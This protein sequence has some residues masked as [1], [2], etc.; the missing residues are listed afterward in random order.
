MKKHVFKRITAMV[1]IFV[2]CVFLMPTNSLG[3]K[4][5]STDDVLVDETQ[6]TSEITT[7]DVTSTELTSEI[8]EEEISEN[9]EEGTSEDI[10]NESAS[11][12][13]DATAEEL[14]E[15]SDEY[16]VEDSNMV[17]AGNTVGQWTLSYDDVSETYNSFGE[18]SARIDELDNAE[19][20]Y[21][22]MGD[23]ESGGLV[24]FDEAFPTKATELIFK[25]TS[26]RRYVYTGRLEADYKV[27][28]GVNF[29]MLSGGNIK[30]LYASEGLS[31]YSSVAG[32]TVNIETL[33][34]YPYVHATTRVK[35]DT[36]NLGGAS[37]GFFLDSSFIDWS[38]G[39]TVYSTEGTYDIT[40]IN[41][42]QGPN[43]KWEYFRFDFDE[44]YESGHV[45]FT[46]STVI[47]EDNIYQDMIGSNIGVVVENENETCSI[48][49]MEN[50]TY[51]YLLS[52][53]NKVEGYRHYYELVDRIDELNNKSRVYTIKITDENSGSEGIS[54]WPEAAKKLIIVAP[55]RNK[56]SPSGDVC[57]DLFLGGSV[58]EYPIETKGWENIEFNR[59]AKIE[60]IKCLDADMTLT[61]SE[62]CIIN[63]LTINSSTALNILGSVTIGT[64]TYQYKSSYSNPVMEFSYD[65]YQSGS[66]YT[67]SY[68]ALNVNKITVASGI[69]RIELSINHNKEIIDIPILEITNCTSAVWSLINVSAYD[70]KI[71]YTVNESTT[72][73]GSRILQWEEDEITT[74]KLQYGDVEEIF[75]TL[76]QVSARINSIN[77]SANDYAI[78][79]SVYH[80]NLSEL[81]ITDMPETANSVAFINET[82][83]DL[84]LRIMDSNIPN[85]AYSLTFVDYNVS[86][87]P[88]NGRIADD[89]Y[90]SKDITI[91]GKT[92]SCSLY[93][94]YDF[95]C[96]GIM[97]LDGVDNVYIEELLQAKTLK[98]APFNA[99]TAKTNCFKLVEYSGKI[100]V[101][102]LEI[103]DGYKMNLVCERFDDDEVYMT[104][105]KY[106]EDCLRVNMI[107]NHTDEEGN[108]YEGV[109]KVDDY[110]NCT[111]QR[112]VVAAYYYVTDSEGKT[113]INCN[114]WI[115]VQNA[116][117]KFG[118]KTETYTIQVANGKIIGTL[119]AKAGKFILVGEDDL[120]DPIIKMSSAT[121]DAKVKLEIQ[122]A[123]LEYGEKGAP[124]N[125][126][127]TAKDL[128]LNNVSNVGTITGN[129]GK[130][131]IYGTVSVAK[132][133][134][135]KDL[136]TQEESEL[137]VSGNMTNITNLGLKGDIYAWGDISVTNICTTR[138]WENGLY[139]DIEKKLT[140]SG[141]IS[142]YEG[143]SNPGLTLIPYE[144]GNIMSSFADETVLIDSCPKAI[145]ADI[146]AANLE[147]ENALYR[148]GNAV[149]AGTYKIVVYEN[150]AEDWSRAQYFE[151]TKFVTVND[152]IEHINRKTEG[153]FVIRLEQSIP[154][155]G[156]IKTIQGTGKTIT[157]GSYYNRDRTLNFTGTF[158]VDGGEV[159]VKDVTLCNSATAN[160][161][162]TL[163]NGAV[164]TLS[165]TSIN[166]LTA[167][168]GTKVIIAND[169][170]KEVDVTIMGTAKC[171]G[172]FVME[173][174]TVLN[175]KGALTAGNFTAGAGNCEL[176]ILSGKAF[177]INGDVSISESSP[178]CI[179]YVDKNGELAAVKLGATMVTA[180]NGKAGQFTT[181]NLMAGTTDVCWL[182]TKSGKVIKASGTIAYVYVKD[183]RQTVNLEFAGFNEAK[184]YIATK[185]GDGEEYVI[186][187]IYGTSVAD[188]SDL[189]SNLVAI[190]KS[191]SAMETSVKLTTSL[192]VTLS[193]NLALDGVNL[194]AAKKTIYA[195]DYELFIDNNGGIT[196]ARAKELNTIIISGG[197][198]TFTAKDSTIN[199]VQMGS[200][201]TFKCPQF[202][203]YAMG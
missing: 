86:L 15:M 134:K 199:Y 36:C 83:R 168:A 52:Y 54:Y 133:D 94:E 55:D 56:I 149:K 190:V 197:T 53:D 24:I 101:N 41:Y 117:T 179:N 160:A 200:D 88:Y 71:G 10:G 43:D 46:T 68:G 79:M 93:M 102:Y 33:F 124:V 154:S 18:V 185:V 64:L 90:T 66:A 156:T 49:L 29:E 67:Y 32:D 137:T 39:E 155:A 191:E 143:T 84:T 78:T 109:M 112:A 127:M 76:D 129:S 106:S 95:R 198:V 77:D 40:T 145:V 136:T 130:L 13:E 122:N 120:P 123:R 21:T 44:E 100:S 171:L 142:F 182:L 105:S 42:A 116:F 16:L 97:S 59:N 159:T 70:I 72:E 20:V 125:I 180:T 14:E 110:N 115:D 26:G 99:T 111:Y 35:I 158:I 203:G 165:D 157:I 47:T 85:L 5:V 50:D 161:S 147:F 92:R 73:S 7:E 194:S 141:T 175:C 104:V 163:K 25:Q 132:I 176:R 60:N 202:T 189:P 186:E 1:L 28:F 61:L 27:S 140:I 196:A 150:Y 2:M 45:G 12:K 22:I 8:E 135:V 62:G 98:W 146:Y 152:A 19:G 192:D 164:V 172:D 144:K 23:A 11:E 162:V 107:C 184:E 121:L 138:K 58:S 80:E 113:F 34:F 87:A 201:G 166:A 183:N 177:T 89:L 4:A 193:T 118:D 63:N 30:E 81:R 153:D 188:L 167:P 69:K 57:K 174:G 187:L 51:Q 3:V 17:M 151:G 139:Y 31:I 126:K 48:V 91:Q 169:V 170:D 128:V 178:L 114:S 6:V 65:W 148:S 103:A 75:N 82:G 173:D 181:E 9:T 195:N 119:P 108:I 37:C 74:I 38:T 96:S 131:D